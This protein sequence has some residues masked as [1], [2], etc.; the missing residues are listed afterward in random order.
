[1]ATA[2]V[3]RSFARSVARTPSSAFQTT[4]RTST[5]L[6]P[7]ARQQYRQQYRSYASEAAKPSSN[8][9]IWALAGAALLGSSGAYVYANPELLS[10]AKEKGPFVPQPADYQQVYNA[11][12]RKLEEH[13]EYEDGSYGPVL[14]R[15]AWHASGTYDQDTKTGG[16]N[17]ATIRFAPEGDHGANSGLKVARDFLVSIKGTY[18]IL[19]GTSI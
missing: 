8:T 14:V 9:W 19:R 1:M 4:S 15:L 3:A 2:A 10:A 18:T 16:S 7:F 11:I 13:D 6:A 5:R 17:G 12:A